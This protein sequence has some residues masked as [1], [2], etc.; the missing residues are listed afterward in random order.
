ETQC[1]QPPILSRQKAFGN[2]ETDA[3]SIRMRQLDRPADEAMVVHEAA[4]GMAESCLPLTHN[5]CSVRAGIFVIARRIAD[6][7]IVGSGTKM[8]FRPWVFANFAFLGG[9]LIES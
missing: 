1:R 5:L 9:A 6:Y 3:S 2:Q 7:Q 4:F 8:R